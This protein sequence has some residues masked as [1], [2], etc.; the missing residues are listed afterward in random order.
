MSTKVVLSVIPVPGFKPVTIHVQEQT[1]DSHV[2]RS[3]KVQMAYFLIPV[4]DFKPVTINVLNRTR[5][6]HVLYSVRVQRSY[7]L[8]V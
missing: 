3:I 7:L 1:R 4:P 2:V 8:R 5:D 6:G